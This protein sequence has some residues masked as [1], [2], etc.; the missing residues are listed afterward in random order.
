MQTKRD[1]LQAHNFV[2]GRMR[3]ALLHGD[4]DALETPTRRFSVAAFAG[5]LVA[6]L[7]AAACGVYGLFFP[8]GDDG[9]RASGSIIVEQ[10]TGARYLY[11][12]TTETLH[13][14]L[15]YASARLV[16]GAGAVVRTVST[17]SLS[18][19][20]HG[21]ALGIPGAPDDVP[22][23]A[24]LSSAPW[25]VCA[26]PGT[27]PST[28]VVLG[29]D[30]PA[31]PLPEDQAVLVAT[32]AGQRHLIWHTRR[33]RVVDATASVVFGLDATRPVPVADTWLNAV[34]AGPDLRPPDLAGRG[35]AGPVVDGVATRVG[36][37]LRIAADATG[38]AEDYRLV[39]PDGL[40]A[41]P[42][43]VA[44]LALADPAN[45]AAYPGGEPRAIAVSSAGVVAAPRSAADLD[46]ADL[47]Q[48]PPTLLAPADLGGRSLCARTA[49][50]GQARQDLVLAAVAG[51]PAATPRRGDDSRAA[52]HIA[53]PA[54]GGVLARTGQARYL[55]TD[56]GLAFPLSPGGA[57][58][59]GYDAAAAAE[60]PA[61]LL[62]L[63]PRGP[64]LDPAAAGDF[65]QR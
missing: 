60:V 48:R 31:A 55:I 4:A 20:R 33:L 13:P 16:A 54:G 62:A 2:V 42:P 30:L 46:F 8:G 35:S 58:A 65:A 11:D 61:T 3:S 40:L 17:R 18:G 37:V 10:E 7:I 36:Q 12:P 32:P 9:W 22:A 52:E 26:A 50:D 15:N 45:R 28:T 44:G 1:Q 64:V 38:S 53:V 59:L 51:L 5:A 39:L 63:V 24:E 21:P 43:T 34:P 6:G 25:L 57:T 27:A 19:V 29:Q 47:P 56:L 41:V 23:P 49:V 14:A